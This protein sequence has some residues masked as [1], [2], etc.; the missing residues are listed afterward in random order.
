MIEGT[1][2]G[3][4]TS[5]T[6]AGSFD[7]SALRYT[8][9]FTLGPQQISQT[10]V[11]GS[12]ADFVEE[13]R[14]V[15]RIL[16]VQEIITGSVQQ[17]RTNTFDATGR[18]TG[19]TLVDV[20]GTDGTTVYSQWDDKGRPTLGLSSTNP[21]ETDCADIP[22]TITYDDTTR[23]KTT[24]I[25]ASKGKGAGCPDQTYRSWEI[26]DADGNPIQI[27]PGN[28]VLDIVVTKSDLVCLP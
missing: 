23:K 14:V 9:V 4:S 21:A 19:E 26:C 25:E 3:S 18:L 20:T 27:T 13:P 24:T 10:H 15:G 22:V 1:A 16:W 7:G 2:T 12:L 28:D 6:V 17:T 8:G 5:G 11:Y